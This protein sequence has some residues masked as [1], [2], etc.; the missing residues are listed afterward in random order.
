ML[1]ICNTSFQTVQYLYF[2]ESKQK[3]PLQT[4]KPFL[5]AVRLL[6]SKTDKFTLLQTF[7]YDICSLITRD[8]FVSRKHG[9]AN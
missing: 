2:E 9:N 6:K 4:S 3:L 5:S 1:L 8:T 7:G